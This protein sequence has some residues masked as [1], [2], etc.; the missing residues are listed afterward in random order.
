MSNRI[1][2]GI[3]EIRNAVNG[4]VY[5]GSAKSIY[6]RF[7]QH[8]HRLRLGNHHSP[9]LQAAWNKRGADAFTFSIIEVVDRDDDLEAREQAHLNAVFAAGWHY[10]ISPTSM[11]PRGITRT[12]ETRARL[13]LAHK[14]Q[15]P[16]LGDYRMTLSDKQWYARRRTIADMN[17]MLAAFNKPYRDF[18]S[19]W[20]RGIPN[21]GC[22]KQP[23]PLVS[24]M[25]LRYTTWETL[26]EH[27]RLT[28]QPDSRMIAAGAARIRTERE[29]FRKEGWGEPSDEHFAANAYEAMVFSVIGRGLNCPSEAPEAT[30]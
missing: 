30:S 19:R 22:D 27:T 7:L 12:G 13:S 14:G 3:Y 18:L 17:R 15:V 8:K 24:P 20:V 1:V 23:A 9:R 28:T 4:K 21:A 26:Q 11:T 6:R 10:N 16:A 29:F 5:V 2:S 25:R